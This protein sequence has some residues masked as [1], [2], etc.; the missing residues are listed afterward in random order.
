MRITTTK[1]ATF[2]QGL[3]LL[4]YGAAGAGKTTLATTTG[5]P[6][7]TL[8]ISAEK[9]LLSISHMDIPV[10]EVADYNDLKQAYAYLNKNKDLYDWVILDSISEIAEKVLAAEKK[11]QPRNKLG[12]YGEMSEKLTLMFKGFRDL[13]FHVVMLCALNRSEGESGTFYGPL[14]PGK[15]LKSNVPYWFDGVYPIIPF[16]DANGEVQRKFLTQ[17]DGFWEAKDRGGLE[18]WE[19]ANLEAVRDKIYALKGAELAFTPDPEP[20]PVEVKEKPVEAPERSAEAPKEEKPAPESD[21]P[22]KPVK[23]PLED[24]DRFMALVESIEGMIHPDLVVR[25]FAALRRMFGVR[26]LSTVSLDALD[27]FYHRL[28]EREDAGEIEHAVAKMI[29]TYGADAVTEQERQDD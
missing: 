13:P 25:F 4:I 19:D 24:S 9:G 15:E 18:L 2:N 26:D 7:R 28:K 12:A 29:E 27:G 6:D 5:V 3:K 11:A 8:I 14:L 21:K 22:A 1:Q 20:L 16:K 23:K 10:A 17:P